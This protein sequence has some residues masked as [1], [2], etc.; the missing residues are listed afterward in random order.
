MA[1]FRRRLPALRVRALVYGGGAGGT[2]R[3]LLLSS[4]LSPTG[5]ANQKEEGLSKDQRFNALYSAECRYYGKTDL[6]IASD[7]DL[8]LAFLNQ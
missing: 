5:E 6:Q 3:F 4:F 2:P 1:I 7:M 8:S